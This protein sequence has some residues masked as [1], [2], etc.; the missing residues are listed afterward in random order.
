M[1][2]FSESCLIFDAALRQR[3]LRSSSA[4]RDRCIQPPRFSAL[5]PFVHGILSSATISALAAPSPRRS[6]SLLR[7]RELRFALAQPVSSSRRIS[8][9]AFAKTVPRASA[10]GGGE[11]ALPLIRDSRPC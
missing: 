2:S 5:F 3:G 6:C 10:I 7:Q 1:S 4:V 8:P 9:H 11:G